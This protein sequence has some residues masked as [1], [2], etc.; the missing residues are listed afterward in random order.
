MRRSFCAL[1]VFL[2]AAGGCAP[3]APPATPPPF[4]PA[5]LEGSVEDAALIC[6]A[7]A[8]VTPWKSIKVPEHYRPIDV[9][10]TADRIWVLLAPPAL[11][12]L[13]REGEVGQPTFSIPRAESDWSAIDTDPTDGSLWLATADAYRL[14]HLTADGGQRRIDLKRV[15]G[16]G[17]L[18]Q[19]RVGRD[20]IYAVPVCADEALWIFNREGEMVDYTFEAPERMADVDT[21]RTVNIGHA[22][23][24]VFMARGEADQVMALNPED[25]KLYRAGEGKTWEVV[26]GPYDLEPPGRYTDTT[27]VRTLALEGG[28]TI[29]YLP[30][31][32]SRLFLHGG[33]PMFLGMAIHDRGV[34][35]GTLLYRVEGNT[36]TPVFEVCGRQALIDVE[37]DGKGYAAITGRE[38]VV[39][40]FGG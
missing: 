20:R 12:S 1:F 5:E 40:R 13:P 28:G 39:G 38:L 34:V 14:V 15:Q 2:S 3:T 17:G 31:L 19:L 37:S 23:P 7:A 10:L 36:L 16:E 6:N 35:R 25:V 29:Y 27:K 11:V 24:T 33:S 22:C 30:D 32:V 18:R 4:T 26:G 8:R 9:A 21:T